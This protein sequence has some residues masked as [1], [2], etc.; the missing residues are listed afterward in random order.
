MRGIPELI[1]KAQDRVQ[2]E[3]CVPIPMRQMKSR[4]RPRE[5]IS[6]VFRLREINRVKFL[7]P[8]IMCRGDFPESHVIDQLDGRRHTKKREK[9]V[10]VPIKMGLS[11]VT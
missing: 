11:V 3:C 10:G 9:V 6:G 1:T 4:Y 5:N 7:M 8:Q 2:C